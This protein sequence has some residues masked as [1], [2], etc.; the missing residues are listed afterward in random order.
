MEVGVASPRQPF[1]MYLAII[2]Q[3]P[4]NNADNHGLKNSNKKQTLE[5]R[6]PSKKRFRWLT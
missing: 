1:L 5:E 2:F 3:L 6:N 4:D